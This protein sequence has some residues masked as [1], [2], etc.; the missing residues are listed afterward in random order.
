MLH[1]YIK[2]I[3][4]VLKTILNFCATVHNV[5]LYVSICFSA[6]V[7]SELPMIFFAAKGKATEAAIRHAAG[8]EVSAEE[9]KKEE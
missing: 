3:F 1:K 7:I 4:P 6:C 8:A 5:K 2:P 9:S